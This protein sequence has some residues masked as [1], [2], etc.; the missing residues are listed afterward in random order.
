MDF[1]PSPKT[2]DYLARVQAFM[3][4]HIAPIEE[5][6]HRD[7]LAANPSADWQ[8]WRVLPVIEELKAKAKAA[9]A[10]FNGPL[11]HSTL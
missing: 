10:A 8:T 2:Q 5:Q 6:Y 3:R 4:E 9:V 11:V 7:N 1:A